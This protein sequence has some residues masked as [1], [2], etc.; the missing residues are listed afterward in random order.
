M[1]EQQRLLKI[2][3]PSGTDLLDVKPEV[4]YI[5]KSPGMPVRF[6]DGKIIYMN[7]ATRRKNKLYGSRVT[8]T[9]LPK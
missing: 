5:V 8:R 3:R 2:N 1:T 7:R 9:R 4:K 6:A